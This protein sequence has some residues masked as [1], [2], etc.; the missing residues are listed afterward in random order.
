MILRQLLIEQ[1]DG[2]VSYCRISVQWQ[3]TYGNRK[4][5]IW[6]KLWKTSMERQPHGTIRVPKT[7]RVP[8][9]ITEELGTGYQVNERSIKEYEEAIWQKEMKPTGTEGW[10]KHVVGEQ[11]YPIE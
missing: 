8:R 10:R 2:I 5:T 11:E 1:L 7:R 3:K 9:R 6:I 4:D